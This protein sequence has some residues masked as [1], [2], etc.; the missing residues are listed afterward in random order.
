MSMGW[1]GLGLL[2]LGLGVCIFGI[3]SG[4]ALVLDTGLLLAS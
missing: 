1:G 3:F 4:R 2:N